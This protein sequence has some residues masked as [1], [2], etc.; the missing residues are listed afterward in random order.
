MGSDP[1]RRRRAGT[2]RRAATATAGPRP[3]RRTIHRIERASF[4]KPSASNRNGFGSI[5]V[6]IFRSTPVAILRRTG[7]WWTHGG[8]QQE[9]GILVSAVQGFWHALQRVA[10]PLQQREQ[11]A[12][13]ARWPGRTGLPGTTGWSWWPGRRTRHRR[14]RNRTG[15][16]RRT[17]GIGPR[18]V[19]ARHGQTRRRLTRSLSFETAPQDGPDE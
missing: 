3:Q 4:Q 15:P 10:V 1:G 17:T 13:R 6:A 18:C 8:S 7:R 2:G 5:S 12:S 19:P 11:P 14:P 9:Q 16:W